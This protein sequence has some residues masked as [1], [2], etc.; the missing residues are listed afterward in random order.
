MINCISKLR[1]KVV[2]HEGGFVPREWQLG[3]VKGG[4]HWRQLQQPEGHR[5]RWPKEARNCGSL[6]DVKEGFNIVRKDRSWRQ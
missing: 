2:A 4:V 1:E 6:G 3:G 5:G